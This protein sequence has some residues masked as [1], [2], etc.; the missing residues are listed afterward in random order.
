MELVKK[1]TVKGQL[2]LHIQI[3]TTCLVLTTIG[4]GERPQAGA[5][6]PARWLRCARGQGSL[7]RSASAPRVQKPC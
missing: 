6:S 3:L 5:S 1:E 4:Q 7:K 2:N